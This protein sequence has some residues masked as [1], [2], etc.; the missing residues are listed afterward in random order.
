MSKLIYLIGSLKNPEVPV[1]GQRLR[2]ATGFDVFDDW[3]APSEDADDWLRDYYKL[4]GFSYAET[5]ASRAAQHIFAFDHHW[6]DASDVGVMLMPAG[7]SGHL[8]LGYLRGQGKPAYIL[9][10]KEPERVDI[11]HNFATAVFFDLDK[12]CEEINKSNVIVAP[13]WD[14]LDGVS[15]IVHTPW[16]ISC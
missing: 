1:I 7:K 13:E 6:L 3:Y 12:L 11:M 10:D 5:L 14:A 15:G 16:K 2:D 4:R 9:F 8:E